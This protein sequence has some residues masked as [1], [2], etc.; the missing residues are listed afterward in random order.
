MQDSEGPWRLLHD[1]KRDNYFLSP[2]GL[3]KGCFLLA[4]RSPGCRLLCRLPVSPFYFKRLGGR[5]CKMTCCRTMT[6][7][8]VSLLWRS[9]SKS[10][11][12]VNYIMQNWVACMMTVQISS[13]LKMLSPDR[14]THLFNPFFLLK[15]AICTS[16]LYSELFDKVM[17]L[18][19]VY[20]KLHCKI[21]LF[22]YCYFTA[23][24]PVFC[25]S[26]IAF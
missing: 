20:F 4:K 2:N 22:S 8:P 3:V 16:L 7:S 17:E 5:I 9:I 15:Q 24:F 23:V 25:T 10:N 1:E 13:Y 26:C 12:F 19:S 11:A 18:I 21:F 14:K 6:S